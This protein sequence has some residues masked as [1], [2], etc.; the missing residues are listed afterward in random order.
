MAYRPYSSSTQVS[1]GQLKTLEVGLP[2]AGAMI[3]MGT[4]VHVEAS[5]PYSSAQGVQIDQTFIKRF[6]VR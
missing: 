2:E 6:P 1:A 3:T 5:V 4:L